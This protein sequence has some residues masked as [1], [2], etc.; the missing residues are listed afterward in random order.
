MDPFQAAKATTCDARRNSRGELAASSVQPFARCGRRARSVVTLCVRLGRGCDGGAGDAVGVQVVSRMRQ[1][2]V[3]ASSADG[4][5]RP[6][7]EH[8]RLSH[9]E[10][11]GAILE[12]LWNKTVVD[13]W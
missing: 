3:V 8:G 1:I 9:V 13:R 4:V 5:L 2:S 12:H 10:R 7:K 6:P 11:A